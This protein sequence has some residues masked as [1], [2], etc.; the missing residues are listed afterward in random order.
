MLIYYIFFIVIAIF[1]FLEINIER[2]VE[3]RLVYYLITALLIL[4]AGLRYNTGYDFDN[5]RDIF[6][7]ASQVGY[8]ELLL[9]PGSFLLIIVSH[10][11]HLNFQ[12]YL[13]IY[14]IGAITI[15]ARFFAEYAPY[16]FTALLVYFPIGF[17]TSE[18]GQIR[19]GLAIAIVLIAFSCLFRN[20]NKWFLFYSVVAVF[21]HI[22]AFVVIPVYFFAGRSFKSRTLILAAS[23]LSVL[24]FFDTRPLFV[25]FLDLLPLGTVFS[26]AS[27][28]LYSEEFG[29]PLG[30]NTSF[31]F[32]M[33][34]FFILVAYR[35]AG[36]IRFKFYDKLIWLYLYGIVL[37]IVFNSIAEFAIRSSLYF[38]TL[39]SLILACI[40][41]LGRGRAE[42][43]LIWSLI[44]LYAFYSMYKLLY[45]PLSSPSFIPYRSVFSE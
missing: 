37:Y 7:L 23:F 36:N 16:I 35:E 27:F 32:R 43:N 19:H 5:Y 21:F 45:D 2:K 1:S 33:A 29:V 11:L 13:F 38:K 15:K 26:K 8:S 18:M 30:F 14:A 17:L 42:K 34:I 24:V 10:A 31:V 6:N 4:M 39:D 41:S 3:H 20:K 40:I 9:E 25:A 12:A 44:V 28:Y 22:S